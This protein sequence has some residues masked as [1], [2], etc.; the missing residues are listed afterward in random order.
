MPKHAYL[1]DPNFVERINTEIPDQ[2]VAAG[3]DRMKDGVLV[4]TSGSENMTLASKGR[5]M[6]EIIRNRAERSQG[7]DCR[8]GTE[9][10]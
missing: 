8:S 7:R 3:R 10:R 1:K 6:L 4:T 2:Y 9:G 5:E